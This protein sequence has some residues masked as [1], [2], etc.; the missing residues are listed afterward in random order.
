[1]TGVVD[2]LR[3]SLVC[4]SFLPTRSKELGVKREPTKAVALAQESFSPALEEGRCVLSEGSGWCTGCDSSTC[5]PDFLCLFQAKET[6]F[7]GLDGCWIC[8]VVMH[9]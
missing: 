7:A 5:L 8:N 4:Y 6:F 3:L 9:D 2:A 1:M